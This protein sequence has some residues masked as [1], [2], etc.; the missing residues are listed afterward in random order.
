MSAPAPLP[1]LT[2]PPIPTDWARFQGDNKVW[3]QTQISDLLA[4][5]ASQSKVIPFWQASASVD[6]LTDASGI[7]SPEDILTATSSGA[8][9]I[10]NTRFTGVGER[11]KI[12]IPLK[13]SNS[14]T[15]GSHFTITVI[16]NTDT[17]HVLFTR[18][19]YQAADDA[20]IEIDLT[21]VYGGDVACRAKWNSEFD[22]FVMYAGPFSAD[23]TF[24]FSANI[25]SP[26]TGESITLMVGTWEFIYEAPGSDLTA[27]V[28]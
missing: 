10:S 1:G 18:D 12:R 14:G 4:L 6:L 24:T 9:T 7:D 20:E 25:T 16:L 27:P 19:F 15:E 23:T 21:S 8:P 13:Y 5:V 11:V 3:F 28:S 17:D 22:P 2:R 26:G